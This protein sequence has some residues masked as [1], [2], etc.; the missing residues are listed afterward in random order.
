MNL[1]LPPMQGLRALEALARHLNFSR[2]AEELNQTPGAIS[3][4]IKALEEALGVRLFERSKRAVALTPVGRRYAGEIRAALQKVSEAT[5]EL[6]GARGRILSIDVLPS[7][8]SRWLLPRLAG[9][10][11]LHPDVELR[12]TASQ[13]LVLPNT[14]GAE[15]AIRYGRPP[16]AGVQAESLADE[17]LF[18]VAAPRLAGRGAAARKRLPEGVPLLRDAHEPWPQWLKAAGEEPAGHG[19]GARYDE[20]ALLLQAAEAGQGVAL[21]RGLLAADALA[22]GQLRR[23]GSVAVPSRNAYYLVHA[24]EAPLSVAAQAFAGWLREALREAG[25]TA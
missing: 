12:V 8:A 2:A 6:R 17:W 11:A 16:W 7:F 23:I 24:A 14:G 22:R 20:S 9:F 19:F 15:L 1:D 10:M 21:A 4:Q 18:P 3:H 13:A 5:R 25:P